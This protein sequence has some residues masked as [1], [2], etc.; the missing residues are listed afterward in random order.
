MKALLV[1]LLFSLSYLPI[2]TFGVEETKVA[3]D[4]VKQDCLA[5]EDVCNLQ[6]AYEKRIAEEVPLLRV[7]FEFKNTSMYKS[8]MNTSSSFTKRS[9]NHGNKQ[10]PFEKSYSKEGAGVTMGV[11]D[12]IM[13]YSIKHP[14]RFARA[15]R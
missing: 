14:R 3:G 9:M 10:T 6:A 2:S 12:G 5:L 7:D 1:A 15:I 11:T 8:T 13:I 4:G